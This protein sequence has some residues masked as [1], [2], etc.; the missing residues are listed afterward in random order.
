MLNITDPNFPVNDSRKSALWQ[1][2]YTLT[3]GLSGCSP[4]SWTQQ[5]MVH[6]IREYGDGTQAIIQWAF[7]PIELENYLQMDDK[8][9]ALFVSTVCGSL[10]QYTNTVESLQ[11]LTDNP[12]VIGYMKRGT[13]VP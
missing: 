13:D 5:G 1:F 3:D 7:D 10:D 9:R 11:T 2:V 12:K 8:N 4:V 6:F